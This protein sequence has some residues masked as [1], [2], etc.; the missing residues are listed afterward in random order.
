[1]ARSNAVWRGRL[2]GNGVQSLTEF[3]PPS[4]DSPHRVLFLGAATPGWSMASDAERR[5]VI[6]PRLVEVCTSWT[7]IGARLIT[8]FDDDLFMVGQPSSTAFT[9]YLVYEV[10]T[11]SIVTAMIQSFRVS[12]DGARLD[13]WFRL[14]ARVGR[15]FFPIE[16]LR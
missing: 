2:P 10:D 9:W 14:E 4:F 7:G 13:Q 8:T 11:L 12:K 5:D 1:L 6:L 15:A 16:D 3:I